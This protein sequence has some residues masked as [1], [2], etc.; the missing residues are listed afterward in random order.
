MKYRILSPEGDYVFGRGPSEFLKDSPETVG[1][2]VLT[3]LL[4]FTGEW[5]L[6]LNEGTPYAQKILGENT[7]P[8]YD[9]A[10]RERILGTPGVLSITDYISYLS[11]DTR[12]LSV[13]ATI[14]TIY[15]ATTIQQV[16]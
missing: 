2:A 10:F 9:Q 5:F 4:L 14:D 1:Q 11:S 7:K 16:L 6:D 12:H 13:D 3:R 8:L 15:G